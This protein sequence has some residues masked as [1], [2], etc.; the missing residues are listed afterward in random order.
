MRYLVA[1][2]LAYALVACNDSHAEVPR[3]V[4]SVNSICLYPNKSPEKIVVFTST[5]F[6]TYNEKE[7]RLSVVGRGSVG[8]LN[9]SAYKARP[10]EWPMVELWTTP[11]S[12]TEISVYVGVADISDFVIQEP[13]NCN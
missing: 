3:V 10:M 11:Q 4:V 8:V 5:Y 2:L 6:H 9:Y 13:R 12:T 7:K 1:L